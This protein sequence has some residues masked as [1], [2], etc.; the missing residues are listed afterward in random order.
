MA[1]VE[2]AALGVLAGEADG[3]AVDEE[4]GVGEELGGA[5]VEEAFA[6]GH[7]DALLVELLHLGMDVEAGGVA[8]GEA[9]ELEDALGGDAGGDV[10]VGFAE[11]AAAI[12]V[13][14]LGER[15]EHGLVL[16]LGGGG[17]FGEEFVPGCS[18]LRRQD[19]RRW[20]WRR[21]DRGTG[22]ALMTA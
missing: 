16:G 5:V 1:L 17:L 3:R 14:V 10:L 4:R 11:F 15:G 21:A 22:A 13:P 9:R 12:V 20:L 7:L 2:G 6:F 18:S 19:R 8:V